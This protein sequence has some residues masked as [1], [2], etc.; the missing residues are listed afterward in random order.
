MIHDAN[1]LGMKNLPDY[2]FLHIQPLLLNSFSCEETHSPAG[3]ASKHSQLVQNGTESTQETLHVP[4]VKTSFLPHCEGIFL[5]LHKSI[6]A[7]ASFSEFDIGLLS[8]ILSIVCLVFFS[9]HFNH[10]ISRL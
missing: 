9:F 10:R 7:S 4:K 5:L 8:H 2:M 1:S 6:L 3:L